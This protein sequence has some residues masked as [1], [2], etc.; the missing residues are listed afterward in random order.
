[1][2][3]PSLQLGNG[4][5]AGKSGNLLA[6]HK[7]NNNFYADELTFARAS[8]GTIVNADGL[9]EEVPY[10]L[11][12]QSNTFDT[13]WIIGA[14]ALDLTSGQSGYDGS[15][16]A[17]LLKKNTSGSRYI[18]QSITRPSGKYS[19]SVYI[20]AESTDWVLLYGYD[21][22]TGVEAYFDLNNGVVGTAS[23]LDS[24]SVVNVGD[25]WFRCT[26]TFTQAITLVRIYPAY[27]NGSVSTGT[28]SGIYIQ[29][30]Q[31]N[32][33]STAKTYY[34]T[35]TRLNVPRVDYL[36]NS[37][38]SLL[39]EPQ[40]T[41]ELPQSNTF[42]DAAWT[43]TNATI[44]ANA[45]TSPDGT[46]NADEIIYIGSGTSQII[47]RNA[48]TT[49]GQDYTLSMYAKY[50]DQQWIQFLS[51]SAQFPLYYANFDIQNGVLGTVSNSTAKIID[52]GNGWYRLQVT[53]TASVSGTNTAIFIPAAVDSGTSV[54]GASLTASNKKAYL[55]GA[56]V[57]AGSYP[58]SYIPTSG[59]TVT[60]NLDA[61]STTGLSNTIG[62][63]E[64]TMFL[65]VDF[66]TVD[67]VSMFLSTRPNSS[68]KIEIYRDG[69]II[70]GELLA[71]SSF[72]ISETATVGRHK[73]A[74][75]YKGGDS[76]LYIN[77]T[78]VG[79]SAVSF[80]FTSTLDDI[81]INSRGGSSFIEQSEYNQVQIYN[82]RLSN[83][84]LATLTTI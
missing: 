53:M 22:S 27:A 48:T 58:T 64:G 36:T 32:S 13:T 71:S 56:Q 11:V 12:Q 81:A 14:S 70:Y 19:Y 23:G 74:L 79:T 75:A 57:E 59:T 44:T 35:T 9:I 66:K 28:D 25:G 55:Y 41:N 33:G 83:S 82:T 37:N 5:W 15:N 4:N 46:T 47:G 69:S 77:G 73:M 49:A 1:M 24:T 61:C 84:E 78:S 6:Y 21:G 76:V 17:W 38:G 62:Q 2:A 60:R 34:P 63:T 80:A 3:E 16:D 26:I 72:T 45:A 10:N 30:A 40:R 20:K 29:D 67:G 54:R 39:L 18:Q 51:S 50:I 7:A 8:T 31:L 43:K 52:A 42:T 68:N 65:D